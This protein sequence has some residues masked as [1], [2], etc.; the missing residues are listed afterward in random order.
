VA[1]LLLVFFQISAS[2]L[3]KNKWAPRASKTFLMNSAPA[4]G[5]NDVKLPSGSDILSLDMPRV[6]PPGDEKDEWLMWFHVRDGSIPKDIAQETTGRILFASSK[7]GIKDW[8]FHEDSPVMGP[9]KEDGNW[10]YFDSEH[11]GL[12]DVIK[13]GMVAQSKFATQNGMFLMYIFGGRNDV[14]TL[15]SGESVKGIKMEI[16]VAVSQDGAHWSRVEGPNPYGSILEPSAGTFDSQFVGWPCVVEDF[17]SAAAEERGRGEYRMY[18]HT[19]DSR[20][21]KYCVALAVARDGL[22]NWKKQGVVWSGGGAGGGATWDAM[23][24]TRRHV[25]K[26]SKSRGGGYK[27]WY[28][29][30]SAGGVPSIGLASSPDGVSWSRCGDKPVL[31]GGVKG[32]WDEGGV[33]SPHLVWL[34]DKKRWRMYYSGFAAGGGGGGKGSIPVC[35][36]GVAESTDEEG[37][38][39][40]RL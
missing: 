29:A 18:Y 2:L 12:G 19:F 32:S 38:E 10:F 22:M 5:I 23:G 17:E 7:D 28:E 35:S 13:P 11:V 36:L 4:L 33:G 9:H 3:N 6:I 24:A 8:K 34:D 30:I 26:L 15:P 16:G 27:M 1:A 37:L 40:K 39:F 25:L 14:T 21:N 20:S 31:E